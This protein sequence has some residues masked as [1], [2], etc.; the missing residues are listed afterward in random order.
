[1]HTYLDRNWNVVRVAMALCIV[2]L[3]FIK[4]CNDPLHYMPN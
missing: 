2:S 1:M 4:G 3:F